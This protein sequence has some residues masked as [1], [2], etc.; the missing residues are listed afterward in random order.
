MSLPDRYTKVASPVGD[1]VLL[2]D[3]RALCACLFEDD[4]HPV[5]LGPELVRDDGA[6][7]A[8]ASQLAE[9]FAG[10]R[11][12]F[13]LPLAPE[14]TEFQQRVWAALRTIPYGATRSYGE[15]ADQI[16]SPN[17]S[18]A[19][20]LANGRNPIAIIVPCHRVIGANGT[21]TGYAGGMDRKRYLLDL[22]AGQPSLV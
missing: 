18:R 19:V 6:F 17:G 9:Y 22:E 7:A 16:G 8:P 11:T 20:G 13:D 15:V 12:D 4:E 14:G 5:A 10:T 1:L 2:G 21:L 3:G